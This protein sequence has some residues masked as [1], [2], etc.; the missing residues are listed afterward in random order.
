MPKVVAGQ[1]QYT[2]VNINDLNNIEVHRGPNNSS[3][4]VL[5]V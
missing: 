3:K 1:I 5:E 4:N 2:E